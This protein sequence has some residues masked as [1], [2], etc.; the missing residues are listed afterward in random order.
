MVFGTTRA[1]GFPGNIPDTSAT[2]DDTLRADGYSTGSDD[3]NEE[4]TKRRRPSNTNLHQQQKARDDSV[5]KHTGT[6]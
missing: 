2:S 4:V 1:V 3:K 6:L 5:F